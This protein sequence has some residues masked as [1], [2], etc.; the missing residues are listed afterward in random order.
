MPAHLVS[1]ALFVLPAIAFVLGLARLPAWSCAICPAIEVI[2]WG[3]DGLNASANDDMKHAPVALGL[4]FAAA[5]LIGWLGGRA[6]SGWI[7]WAS[8]KPEAGPKQPRG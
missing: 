7:R 1:I 6:I 8:R 3:I 5:S 4:L 2:V